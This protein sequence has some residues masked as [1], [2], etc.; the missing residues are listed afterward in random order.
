MKN[1]LLYI[2]II[3]S[4]LILTGCEEMVKKDTKGKASVYFSG[5]CFWCIE[6]PFDK[7]DGVIDVISGYSGGDEENPTYEE[8]SSGETGHRE[9]NQ[10]IYDPEII[11]YEELLDVFWRQIDPTDAGGS[12][13]DR[14]HQYTSAIYY[15]NVKE[16]ALAEKSRDAL[17]KT[18]RYSGKIVTSIEKFKSFYNAEEYHQDYSTKN[19]IRY[20]LYRSRSGRDKYLES[21][22][23]KEEDLKLTLTPIQ[24]KVTQ[25]DGTEPAF[26]NEYWDNKKDGIYVDIVS[27]EALFSSKDKFKSGTGWPSFTK[28]LEESNVV[29]KKD[30]SWLG[31]RTEVRSKEGDSHLGH[32]FK[33]GPDPTGLRYCINSASL[34]FIPVKDLDKNGYEKYVKLF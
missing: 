25:E 18:G 4:L 1:K 13:V 28:P 32:L 17:A 26:K 20:K 19:P 8:V 2:L 33:D 21:V 16:K 3:F 10:V 31:I 11:S 24:Y 12:F 27:G 22:W 23:S 14:G 6:P 7:L 29:E 30:I 34:K 9:A 5:G 15:Q